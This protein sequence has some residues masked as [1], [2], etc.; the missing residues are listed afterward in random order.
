MADSNGSGR[1]YSYQRSVKDPF[2]ES[3]EGFSRGEYN[4]KAD[5]RLKKRGKEILEKYNPANVKKSRIN[6][7]S[8]FWMVTS[9]AVFYFTDFYLAVKLDPRVNWT[10][11]LPGMVFL[12]ISTSIGIFC[13]FWCYYVKGIADYE[14]EYPFIIPLATVSFLVGIACCCVALWPVWGWF[15]PLILFTLVMGLIFATTILPL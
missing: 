15:T 2:S 1:G 14:K 9:I 6:T 4:A 7:H 13:V 12:V 10:W 3:F 8:I 11:L 5:A